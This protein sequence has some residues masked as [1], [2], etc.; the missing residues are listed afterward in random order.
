[1]SEPPSD[2]H[3]SGLNIADAL[4]ALFKHKWMLF[5][6]TALG[7]SAAAAVYIFY[8]PIYESQAKLLVRY[9]VDT[10]SVDAIDAISG[11]TTENGIAS[12]V[13]ILTSRDLAVQAAEAIGVQRLLP[14][15][16]DSADVNDAARKISVGLS[17]EARKGSDI[18]IVSFRDRDPE[19]V[20]KVLDQIVT[21]YFTKHLE[22]HRSAGAFDFVTEQT[23]QVR[24][25][26]NETE[27]ELEAL[28]TKAGIASVATNST[29]LSGEIVRGEDQLNSEEADLAEQQARVDQMEQTLPISPGTPAAKVG[30][31]HP[32]PNVN[33]TTGLSPRSSASPQSASPGSQHGEESKGKS[34][35]DVAIESSVAQAGNDDIQRYQALVQRLGQLRTTE[36]EMLAKYTPG[37][38]LVKSHRAQ[39]EALES[40]RR[41]METRFT[42]LAAK[43]PLSGA[44]DGQ[45]DLATERARLAGT[46][47]KV[48]ILKGRLGERIKQLSEVGSKIADLE[49]K[50]EL[51][52]TNYK[53]FEG[54]LEKARVDE[55]LDPSKMPNIS[56]VQKPTPPLKVVKKRNKVALGLAVGG[57]GFG[58]A[59]ALLLEIGI[60]RTFKRPR[61]LE[62]QLR[63]PLLVSIPWLSEGC[64]GHPGLFSGAKER[65]I[66]TQNGN[67]T[68]APW[69][70]GHFIRP[71]A[72]A[73]R[74]RLG[75]YFE[76]GRMT[77]KPKLVGVAGFS[78]GAG[79]STLA[80]GLA[81]ALSE[82]DEG[83]VLLVDV[84]L[85]PGKAHPFFQGKPALSLMAALQPNGDRQASE[86]LYLAAVAPPGSGP[87]TRAL[88]RFFDLMPNLKASEFDY[89][90]FDMPPLNE[91]S[92]TF[93]MAAFMDKLLLV[94]EAEKSSRE[95]I[96]RKYQQLTAARDNISIVFNKG[97][98]YLPKVLE[99]L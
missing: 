11:R 79:V 82:M 51:E 96:K 7:M 33:V 5:Y 75:L 77:H 45:M 57:V 89:I 70:A 21:H 14:T 26:L 74:D 29:T 12:E 85:G 65:A 60:N 17:A 8:P 36:L 31:P 93:G 59:F 97:R 88:K 9:V 48:E 62:A 4:T 87:T 84:N 23:N 80:A 35:G 25:R 67:G 71:Y 37:N 47:A 63:V 43:A 94:A 78:E 72:E 53:Y 32:P 34:P 2:T 20:T 46:R 58:I 16:G 90:I 27:A 50:K 40:K 10:S 1:M 19:L 81:A 86:N 73:I 61:D 56:A 24:A 6:C 95:S 92:A 42:D 83:K 66:I 91:T 13:E 55:A 39:I 41:A 28:K 52:E 76:L 68:L 64:K 54:A 44:S 38:Q 3:Q 22:V 69:E 15:A 49:R 99:D 98:S 30:A 18:I